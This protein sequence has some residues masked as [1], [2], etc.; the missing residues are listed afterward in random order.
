LRRAT[1]FVFSGVQS[2]GADR[3]WRS[4]SHTGDYCLKKTA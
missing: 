3:W 2:V 1:L 4:Q